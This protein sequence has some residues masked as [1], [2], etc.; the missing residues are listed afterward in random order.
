MVGMNAAEVQMTQQRV[1]ADAAHPPLSYAEYL[2]AQISLAK[3]KGER[4]RLRLKAAAARLLG[5][6]GY[7][8]LRVSDIHEEADVSN[9][10]FYVYFKNKE[11]ISQEVLDGFLAFL[12]GFP[13]GNR[14]PAS[15]FGSIRHGNLRYAQMFAANAGLMRCVFQFADEFPA[16]AAKWHAWNA[17]WRDRTIR[18][19]QR[20]PD[21]ALAGPGELDAAVIALGA[22]ID[23]F[24]RMAFIERE[25]SLAGT[26][27]ESDPAALAELLSKLWIRA[28][29]AADPDDL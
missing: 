19:M 14:P 11:E 3:R 26:R 1:G 12:E 16:F 8:D 5:Q 24:L 10:L 21:I 29:F 4:T 13:D 18:A 6:V 15:R 25:P 7:R 2:S 27:Y 9:A 22:M 17:R 20:K 23:A 28:L